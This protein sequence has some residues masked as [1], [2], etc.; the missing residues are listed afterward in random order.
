MLSLIIAGK[1]SRCILANCAFI[2]RRLAP[3][4]STIC[5]T[6]QLTNN[7]IS[8]LWDRDQQYGWQHYFQFW[9]AFWFK[10]FMEWFLHVFG[11]DTHFQRYKGGVGVTH[12]NTEEQLLVLRLRF[13]KMW[14]GGVFK[15]RISR[16]PQE[17]KS[18]WCRFKFPPI[19][20][21]FHRLII[22]WVMTQSSQVKICDE[23]R[24]LEGEMRALQEKVVVCLCSSSM[25]QNE[26]MIN[27]KIFSTRTSKNLVQL[28]S[29]IDLA[30]YL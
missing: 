17:G 21:D 20:D 7:Q 6:A 28:S 19:G 12:N 23:A 8:L 26:G 16:F 22:A 10:H 25:V 1:L 15:V 27:H 24:M 9:P 3:T 2:N 14:D 13:S 5:T 30:M 18:R 11:S 29:S 4:V